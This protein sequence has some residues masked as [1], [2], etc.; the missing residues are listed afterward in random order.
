MDRANR[1][2]ESRSKRHLIDSFWELI[3][4][5][6]TNECKKKFQEGHYADA[7]ETSFKLIEMKVKKLLKDKGVDTARYDGAVPLMHDAFSVKNPLIQLVSKTDDFYNNIQ[8]GY[9]EIYAGAFS[10]IRN[11]KAHEIMEITQERAIHFIFLANLLFE[12]LEERVK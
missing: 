2:I 5:E 11:Q 4:E 1:E 8:Q 12:R 6:L 9:M 10:A 3:N 7:V